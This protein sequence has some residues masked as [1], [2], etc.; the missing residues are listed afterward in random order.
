MKA[1][2][3]S[4]IFTGLLSA[5]AGCGPDDTGFTPGGTCEPVASTDICEGGIDE[6]CDGL[7]DC[8]D[9]DCSGYPSCPPP[10]GEV[11]ATDLELPLPDG[12]QPGDD[13]DYFLGSTN[14]QGFGQGA[15]LQNASDIIS[16]CVVMEHSWIR[17][18]QIEMVC[19]SGQT[20]VLQEFLGTEGDEVYLGEPNDF[21]DDSTPV[22]GVGYKYCWTPDATNPPFL[23]YANQHPEITTLPPGDYQ[24]VGSFNDLVGCTL[25]GEWSIKVTDL[26]GIDNGYIFEWSLNFNP[27]IIQD[28]SIW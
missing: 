3:G 22:P 9:S 28:C 1:L 24:A 5:L 25:D 12:P 26:W 21:D 2:L 4:V 14:L 10:C 6:D 20:L 13:L 11:A 7:I 15:T 19:P 27:D 16:A 23:E 17:D 18:L 8:A